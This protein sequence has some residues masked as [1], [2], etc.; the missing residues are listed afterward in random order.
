MPNP[1]DRISI[2]HVGARDHSG[3]VF[4]APSFEDEFAYTFYEADASAEVLIG[5]SQRHVK[6]ANACIG[7]AEQN[8]LFHV[9]QHPPSSSLFVGNPALGEFCSSYNG[10]D[11]PFSTERRI[12]RDVA[13]DTRPLSA[14][15]CLELDVPPP[16]VLI[17]DVQ[18]AESEILRSMDPGLLD[19]V[20]AI[21]TEAH[22]AEIYSGASGFADISSFL[23]SRGFHFVDFLRQT[24]F[25]PT[26]SPVGFQGQGFFLEAD[27]VFLKDVT[28][29]RPLTGAAEVR[30]RTKLSFIS[31]LQKQMDY[32][33]VCLRGVDWRLLPEAPDLPRYVELM[34]EIEGVRVS[35]AAV[36]PPSLDE[37][38]SATPDVLACLVRFLTPQANPVV[39]TLQRNGLFELAQYY[40]ETARRTAEDILKFVQSAGIDIGQAGVS[41]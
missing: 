24:R 32:A 2:H 25:R 20:L 3:A 17:L 7:R 40:G 26:R 28:R 12:V 13:L 39:L 23:A 8:R 35:A 16:D 27:A 5:Q 34:R 6:V 9:M 1:Q 18:G 31:L 4:S 37:P 11:M 41:S 14:E 10:I 36:L 19:H 22:M 15:L 29:M 30:Q 21:V 38:F 33:L